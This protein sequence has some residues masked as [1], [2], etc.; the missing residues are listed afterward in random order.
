V[1]ASYTIRSRFQDLTGL[2]VLHCHILDHEDQGMMVPIKLVNPNTIGSKGMDPASLL[3]KADQPAPALMLPDAHGS[4]VDLRQFKG[5]NVILVFFKGIRCGYC[6]QDLRAIVR[7]SRARSS[8]KVE[9]VAVSDRKVDDLP[10]AL[11]LL[12]VTEAD[13]F[14]LLIDEARK[15]FKDFGCGSGVD[16]RHGLFL[17]DGKGTVRSRY[18]G[19]TP[20]GDSDEVFDRLRLIAGLAR[21]RARTVDNVLP[22]LSTAPKVIVE[23]APAAPAIP[24]GGGSF[25]D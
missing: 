15:S 14:H 19:E 8:D 21:D 23:S 3:V 25:D 6:V 7:E 12:G 20:F 5:R 10:K 22:K 1:G 11:K 16:A 13:K 9:I 4:M 24:I 17:V 2:S 18:I